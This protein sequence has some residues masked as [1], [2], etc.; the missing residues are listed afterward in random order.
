[1][2]RHTWLAAVLIILSGAAVLRFAWLRADPPA[3]PSVGVVWHDEG[4][5]VHNARN[6]ALWGVWRTDDWNPVFVTPVFTA[7]EYAA[8]RE[9]GVGTWQARTVP[10]LSGLAVVAL[11]MAGLVT[12]GDRRTALVGG[13]L[14]ATNFIFVMWNRAA[15]ME[16]PMVAFIVAGWAAY[17]LAE[18]R[19]MWGLA[20][21]AGAVLAWF[22]KASAAFFLAALAFDAAVTLTIGRSAGLRGRLGLAAPDAAQSRAAAFT[23]A[24]AALVATVAIVLFVVPHWPQYHFYNWQMS[25]TRKP[26]YGF[27]DLLRRASWLP[28]VSDF[29]TRMWLVVVAAAAAIATLAARWRTTKPATRLLVLWVVAGLLELVVHDSGNERRYVLFIPALVALAA[30]LVT[31]REPV[32]PAS[33][34]RARLGARLA[35]LPLVLALGYLVLGSL[36]R[37][38]FLAQVAAGSFH[39]VVRL[40]AVAAVALAAVVL[41]AWRPLIG[42]LSVRRIAPA[43]AVALVVAGVGWNLVEYAGWARGRT[44]LDYQA[45]VDVGRLLPPGTPVQGILAN[46]LSLE[47]RIR[48]LFIGNGF[49]NYADRLR[50]DDVRYILTLDVPHL[51]YESQDRSGLIPELLDRYPGWHTVATFPVTTF[52]GRPTLDRAALIDKFPAARHA[53]D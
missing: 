47:N 45:S 43:V 11:L 9:L 1:M 21:G 23:L 26:S 28:V 6:R 4:A 40:A 53:R 2:S 15:L 41:A 27:H 14:V 35:A 31:S 5:W 39:V 52:D 17:A 50:R 10:A 42:W 34:A 38:G 12:V 25:V 22:T 16:S 7:L 32:L 20:A 46:G 29:F 48:P 8:F 19:P 37:L 36:L 51:G 18:R 3:S 44:T 33:L 13:A 30:L 49:G 24:G